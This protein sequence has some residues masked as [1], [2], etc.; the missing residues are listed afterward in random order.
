MKHRFAAP[1]A[2]LALAPCLA[3]MLAACGG[4]GGSDAPAPV[5][6]TP[7]PENLSITAPA[8]GDIA[9]P[10]A[11]GNSAAG[12][13]KLSYSWDFGD[14][15]AVST[16]AAPKH[17]F[18]KS[19]EY[20]VKLRVSNEAGQAKEVK[21]T[22]TVNNQAAVRGLECSGAAETGWCW[23]APR[24]T[25]HVLS[26]ITF[27]TATTGWRVGA[28]GEIF[29]TVDGGKTWVRQRSG[30]TADLL[31]VLFWDEK[32]AWIRGSNGT[33]LGTRD[34][35]STWTA[36]TTPWQDDNFGA[37]LR[38]QGERSLEFNSYTA[39]RSDDG[40]LTW[41]N[42]S[43]GAGL[44]SAGGGAFLSWYGDRL[45]RYSSLNGTAV[46]VLQ[47]KDADG[48]SYNGYS[49]TI[50]AVGEKALIVRARANG[51]WD[52]VKQQYFYRQAM[53]RSEDRGLTWSVLAATGLG[54]EADPLDIR[55]LDTA[56][57]VLLAYNYSK[58]FRSEDGGL[59]WALVSPAQ[60]YSFSSLIVQGTRVYALWSNKPRYSDDLGK[61][62][63]DLS[64]PQSFTGSGAGYYSLSLREAGAGLLIADQQQGSFVSLDKG[65]SWVRVKEASN[66]SQGA[67]HAVAFRDAKNGI[68]VNSKGELLQSADGGKSWTLKRSD[69]GNQ[70]GYGY[71]GGSL[72]FLN[73]KTGYLLSQDRRL[74]KTS[75]GGESWAAGL[76]SNQWS[77]VGFTD[78]NNGWARNDYGNFKAW[79]TRDGASS[80]TELA[81]PNLSV[82]DLRVDAANGLTAVGGAGVIA[83]S[84]DGGKTW[85][86]RYTGLRDSLT[87]VYSRDGKS[88]WVLGSGGVLLRSDDAGLNWTRVPVPSTATLLDV[89]FSDAMNG[90]IVGEQG[91]VLATR[92]GGK[93]WMPQASGTRKALRT[94]QLMD[95]RTGWI[96]GDEGTLLATG[97]GGH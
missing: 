76:N 92:D 46:E 66:S 18:A 59:S 26:S 29:K 84:S 73:A 93:T 45:Q 8:Q 17:Q 72:Q 19:G 36:M 56:G 20:E 4:G 21:Y 1:A 37:Y 64:L 95:S 48:Y 27:A 2:R 67:P 62:W 32:T 91:T 13:G 50:S 31:E 24:P 85:A 54:G 81:L 9:E 5:P 14:G 77:R 83:Q 75:D 7:V 97:T 30:V 58:I 12:L 49:S 44:I 52:P 11:F 74:Y 22:L 51:Q 3:L 41:Q 10:T 28:V 80:W 16:E 68:L 47:L 88:Y 43:A 65:L 86:L 57:Q 90:W 34:G 79:V 23:Q 38:V 25:G 61:T 60:L 42:S 94:V 96:V 78:E 40:G 69:L 15:S 71:F 70:S 82:G 53:W 39:Y 35:G 55:S 89:Q 33:L 6:P 87:R 63:S